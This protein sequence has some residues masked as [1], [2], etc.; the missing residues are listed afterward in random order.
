MF[1]KGAD[2]P[3]LRPPTYLATPMHTWKP[4]LWRAIPELAGGQGVAESA[5]GPRGQIQGP[6]RWSQTSEGEETRGLP[7]GCSGGR[8]SHQHEGLPSPIPGAHV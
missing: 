7:P 3:R 2:L 6:L 1:Q 5:G 4:G 8:G